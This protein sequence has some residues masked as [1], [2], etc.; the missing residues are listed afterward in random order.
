[1]PPAGTYRVCVEASINTATDK[2]C[3]NATLDADGHLVAFVLDDDS[4]PVGLL[5]WG[6]IKRLFR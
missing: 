2:A 6:T 3:G 1:L 4:T 5:T